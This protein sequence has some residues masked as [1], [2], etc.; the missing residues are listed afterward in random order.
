MH[1]LDQADGPE[2]PYC[3]CNDTTITQRPPAGEKGVDW[4]FG[5]GQAKCNFCGRSFSVKELPPESEPELPPAREE[6]PS[7]VPF[8]SVR[9]PACKST[10][11]I[12][13]KS[14]KPMPEGTIKFRY[15]KCRACGNKF[16]S[17]EKIS[18]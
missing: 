6:P 11:T 10:N 17:H 16:R 5:F 3:G 2:C 1:Y 14:P 13:T 15:H 4:W 7:S 9:C 8:V 12:V 18:N